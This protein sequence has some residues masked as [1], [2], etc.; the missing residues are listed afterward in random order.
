MSYNVKHN[1]Q[2]QKFYVNVGGREAF[3]KYEKLGEGLLDLKMLFV[4][5]NLRGVGIAEKVLMRA[6]AYAENNNL[7]INTSCSYINQFFDSHPEM[8]NIVSP[9]REMIKWVLH[10]N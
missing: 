1:R 2:F 10:Y 6:L 3:L 7:K 4:P 5:K 9:K 8:K